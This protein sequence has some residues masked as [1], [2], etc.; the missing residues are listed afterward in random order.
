[1]VA[2]QSPRLSVITPEGLIFALAAWNGSSPWRIM[3]SR[4]GVQVRPQ[5]AGAGLVDG[6]DAVAFLSACPRPVLV[7]HDRDAGAAG[8]PVVVPDA[9]GDD[10][11]HGSDVPRLDHFQHERVAAG[12]DVLAV[13]DA[14]AFEEGAVAR[15]VVGAGPGVHE[16][17]PVALDSADRAAVLLFLGGENQPHIGEGGGQPPADVQGLQ[18]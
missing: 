15:R 18:P 8:V 6:Y 9:G 10:L 2:V 11:Q 12:L 17:R 13:L 7:G 4:D 3:R 5:H 14:G 1:M 16:H